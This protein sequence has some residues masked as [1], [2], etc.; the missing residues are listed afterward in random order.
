MTVHH[1]QRVEELAHAARPDVVEMRPQRPEGPFLVST[2][3]RRVPRSLRS[4]YVPTFTVGWGTWF[5]NRRIGVRN[6]L[7][8]LE[9]RSAYRGQ[10]AVS[11]RGF[12]VPKAL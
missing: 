11:R 7:F 1:R 5:S 9:T 12:G 6:K 4:R 8:W 10:P 2:S 3:V